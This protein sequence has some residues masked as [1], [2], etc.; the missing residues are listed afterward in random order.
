MAPPQG[1]DGTEPGGEAVRVREK[2]SFWTRTGVWAGVPTFSFGW[3]LGAPTSCK[4]VDEP[5]N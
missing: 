4:N 1:S 3:G 2:G 5:A